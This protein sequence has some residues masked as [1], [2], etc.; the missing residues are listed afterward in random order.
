ML[1]YI[2]VGYLGHKGK[3]VKPG[4]E[5]KLTEE[6]AARLGESVKLSED[7]DVETV[8]SSELAD[9]TNAQLKEIAES[10]GLEGYESLKKADLIAL[11]EG[12]EQE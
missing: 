12:K 3:L 11:I 6:Q 7:Q 2:A 10:E 9:Y 4:S 5:V 1:K 8:E